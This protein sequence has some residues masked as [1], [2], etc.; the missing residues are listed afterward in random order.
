M[1][2]TTMLRTFCFS[3]LV[4]GTEK[5]IVRI[6]IFHGFRKKVTK[7]L[8]AVTPEMNC[9]QNA[10]GLPSVTSAVFLKLNYFGKI[11]VSRRNI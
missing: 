1:F 11:W 3:Q 9:A 4:S 7:G 2:V 6:A 10:I 8:I 5:K